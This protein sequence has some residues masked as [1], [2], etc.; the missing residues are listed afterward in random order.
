MSHSFNS[1]DRTTHAKI[2]FTAILCSAAVIGVLT[3]GFAIDKDGRH[4]V[5]AKATVDVSSNKPNAV[6]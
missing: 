1:T 3:V 2:I 4:V 6:R 5:K